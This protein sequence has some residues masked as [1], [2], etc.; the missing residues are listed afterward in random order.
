MTVLDRPAIARHEAAHTVMAYAVGMLLAPMGVHAADAAGIAY[1]GPPHGGAP[2]LR[3]LI[4]MLGAGNVYAG[5]GQAEPERDEILADGIARARAIPAGEITRENII[6]VP[7][8]DL[9]RIFALL[10]LQWPGA[11]DPQLL[12]TYRDVEASTLAVLRRPDVG[13][14]IEAVAA[15]L[16][17]RGRLGA[18][19]M[20]GLIEPTAMVTAPEFVQTLADVFADGRPVF[21]AFSGGKDSIALL[22]LCKPWHDRLTL[23]W[24]NTGS[25]APHMVEFVRAYGERY[26]LIELHP[27]S[28]QDQWAAAG[29]PASLVPTPHALG[30][31]E[32]RLQAWTSCC[33][34]NR[35]APVNDFLAQQGPCFLVHGQRRDDKGPD[36]AIL[37]G[38]M[39]QEVE[40]HMPLWAWSDDEVVDY[41]DRQG[42][43]LPSQYAEI[44]DSLE[45]IICPVI[46]TAERLAYLD[47]HYPR[48]AAFVRPLIEQSLAAA[49]ASLGDLRAMLAEPAGDAEST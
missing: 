38:T 2:P 31:Q 29:I 3:S 23:L 37:R 46:G 42:L 12:A 9:E 41:I 25:M 20:P 10:L 19:D 40:V 16:F 26:R 21:L 8:P 15:A 14:S 18:E 22:D 7:R 39:S 30:W 28:L 4:A 11:T 36:A 33:F 49:E 47:R 24:T 6:D 1:T 34:A 27:R 43:R 48:A 44:S 17:A 5:P 32:P 45:C 13:R 35:Q